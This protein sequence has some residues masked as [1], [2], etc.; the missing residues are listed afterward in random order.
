MTIM[1]IPCLSWCPYAGKSGILAKTEVASI[2]TAAPTLLLS[3]TVQTAAERHPPAWVLCG[4]LAAAI[5][6]Q[7]RTFTGMVFTPKG[8]ALTD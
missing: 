5:Q 7:V 3:L 6:R 2:P 1:V 4:M 8:K